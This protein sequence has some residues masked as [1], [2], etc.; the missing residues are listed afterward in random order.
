[1]TRLEITGEPKEA[2]DEKA[3]PQTSVKLAKEGTQWGIATADGY[4]ADGTKVEEL[5][6]KLAKLKSRGPVLTKA[7]YHKKVEVADDKYQRKISLTVD[8]KDLV[9]FLGTSPSIKSVHLRKAGSDEVL[10]VGELTTWEAGARPWDWVDRA[11]VKVPDANVYGV[12]VQNKNG[13]I[14]LKRTADGIWS[15]DGLTG[16]AKKSAI[17]DLVRKASAINLEEPVGKTEKPEHG[18]G[19]PLATITLTTGTSTIAGKMP[20]EMRTEVVRIGAKNEASNRYYAKST[21][22][23]YV[24]ELASWAVDPLIN[25]G[26]KDLVEEEKKP[27]ATKT[28]PAPAPKKR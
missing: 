24:V 14:T 8:G 26:L 3:P 17:D 9:F 6:G 11:F 15:A 1:M 10:Q 22:S 16:P 4:P 13:M 2:T 7:T 28:T 20:D 18:L 23:P 5:L 21:T 19:S 25:K 12:V 27:D